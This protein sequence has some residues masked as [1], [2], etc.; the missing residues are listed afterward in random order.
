MAPSKVPMVTQ[1]E[2]NHMEPTIL[3]EIHN[4]ASKIEDETLPW[5]LVNA[6]IDPYTGYMLK[7]KFIIQ[8][9]LK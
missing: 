3:I 7:Y 2:I 4:M 5:Y 6:F 1:E 8:P 9:K